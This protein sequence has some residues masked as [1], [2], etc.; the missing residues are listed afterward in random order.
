MNYSNP[1]DLA[2]FIWKKT[3]K[4]MLACFFSGLIIGVLTHLFMITNKI[5]N[6]DDVTVIPTMGLGPYGGRW[7]GDTVQH[8]FSQWSAPGVNGL[9]AIIMM[10]LAACLAADAVQIRSYSGVIVWAALFQTFPVMASNMTFMF[11]SETFAA[12]AF[13]M[14]LA[15]DLMLRFKWGFLPAIILQMLS[16]ACYQAYFPLGVS[17]T[18]LALLRI[19]IIQEDFRTWEKPVGYYIHRFV[20]LLCGGRKGECSRDVSDNP[21]STN[22]DGTSDFASD[23]KQPGTFIFI[24]RCL[25][26]L[27][28][29]ALGMAVYLISFHFS[30]RKLGGLGT[31]QYRG[32][33]NIGKESATTYLHAFLRA[34]HRVLEFFV[35]DPPGYAEGTILRYNRFAAFLLLLFWC[36]IF[37]LYRFYQ[38]GKRFVLYLLLTGLLPLSMGLIYVM[39]PETQTASTNM[40]AGYLAFYLILITFCE[41]VILKL[42]E[43]S[44]QEVISAE[45]Q[46]DHE[47]SLDKVYCTTSCRRKSTGG[48][49][50]IREILAAALSLIC[51]FD[52]ALLSFFYYKL[53]NTAYYRS[54]IANERVKAMYNRVL[55]KLEEQDGYTYDSRILIAGDWWPEPNVLSSYNL[56][57]DL[58]ND[59][60]GLADEHGL[61]TTGVRR[62]YMRLFLG[63]NPPEVTDEEEAAIEQSA[64]YKAMPVFPADGCILK[65]GDIYVVKLAE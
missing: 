14:C 24:K 31:V 32:I 65:F 61:M 22:N 28:T 16:M 30:V 52:M 44:R 33:E 26:C 17:V 18:V 29:L 11:M 8:I 53:D 38:S 40:I 54:Y 37:F 19:L 35:T 4:K 50:R 55:V 23:R 3:S 62:G 15:V 12:A 47:L 57:G 10:S 60:D 6:W 56:D 21:S 27:L 5:P 2:K 39:S 46:G 9:W 13:L 49:I 42:S 58:Y 41:I 48:K 25:Y 1:F 59:L 63:I 20:F 64:E 7:L 43:N 51:V 34:Y 45:M 36:L